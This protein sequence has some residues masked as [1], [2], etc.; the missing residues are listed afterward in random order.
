VVKVEEQNKASIKTLKRMKL[1]TEN[2][3]N[4]QSE[5]KKICRAIKK[6]MAL[7]C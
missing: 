7:R 2:Y 5:A 6:T 3:K 1:N 4:K